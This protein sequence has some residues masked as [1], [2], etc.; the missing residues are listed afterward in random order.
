MEVKGAE[1][2]E[3]EKEE[4]REEKEEGER[5]GQVVALF[6]MLRRYAGGRACHSKVM[7][8]G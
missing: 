7:D 3:K 4:E 2:K 5:Q 1:K 6:E 8:G